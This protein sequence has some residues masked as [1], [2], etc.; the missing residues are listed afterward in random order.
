M[1]VFLVLLKGERDRETERERQ[2]GREREGERERERER[3]RGGY[4]CGC[5]VS[6]SVGSMEGRDNSLAYGYYSL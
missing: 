4:M 5:L 2:R 1:R 3:G 6:I